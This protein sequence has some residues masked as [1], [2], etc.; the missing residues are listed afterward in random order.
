MSDSVEQFADGA[1]S[2]GHVPRN[3]I[4]CETC[5]REAAIISGPVGTLVQI[6]LSMGDMTR[7]NS[8]EVKKC[9]KVQ[10]LMKPHSKDYIQIM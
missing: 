5:W 6:T 3:L 4:A 2:T 1:I 8:A 10:K 9:Q 7:K